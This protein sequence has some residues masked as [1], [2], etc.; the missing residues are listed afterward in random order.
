[1]VEYKKNT[2]ESPTLACWKDGHLESVGRGSGGMRKFLP[3][4]RVFVS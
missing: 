3:H 2:L 4:F 1:M